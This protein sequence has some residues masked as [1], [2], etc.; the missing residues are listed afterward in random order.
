MDILSVVVAFVIGAG[1]GGYTLS[2]L[3]LFREPPVVKVNT[4]YVDRKIYVDREVVKTI[5]KKNGTVIRSETK[6]KSTNVVSTL[7]QQS[8]VK[9]TSAYSLGVSWRLNRELRYSVDTFTVHGAIRIGH[10]PV[11]AGVIVG[12][13]TLGVGVRYEW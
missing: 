3:G 11:W 12:T 6:D 9:D 7:K 1:A 5:T 13:D 2:R 4:V 8:I 10:S